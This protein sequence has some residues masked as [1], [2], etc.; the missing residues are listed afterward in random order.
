MSRELDCPWGND[1]CIC[2][3]HRDPVSYTFWEHRNLF[4]GV[5][6][7]MGVLILLVAALVCGVQIFRGKMEF[8]LYET[9]KST[10]V[11]VLSFIALC[12]VGAY[13]NKKDARRAQEERLL[14][15]VR[16]TSERVVDRASKTDVESLQKQVLELEAK[17]R[18]IDLHLSK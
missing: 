7:F 17:I 1:K 10:G 2:A 12:E 18:K 16:K 3:K 4:Y 15:T 13:S 9:A 8:S 14:C 11:I 6:G 5:Y